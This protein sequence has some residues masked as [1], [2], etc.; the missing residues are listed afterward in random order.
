MAAFT[1]EHLTFTYPLADRPALRD[2]SLTVEEAVQAFVKTIY[3]RSAPGG[4]RNLFRKR[5][6]CRSDQ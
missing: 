5:E 4:S 1:T 6:N 2:V 3:A